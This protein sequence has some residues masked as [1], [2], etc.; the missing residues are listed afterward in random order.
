MNDS[1]KRIG[2]PPAPKVFIGHGTTDLG[3][4]LQ[5]IRSVATGRDY[6]YPADSIIAKTM[7]AQIARA[8]DDAPTKVA[9]PAYG[10]V[11]DLNVFAVRDEDWIEVVA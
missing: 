1:P 3:T 9:L 6:A 7:A 2:R 11:S 4:R 5:V 10:H 8:G